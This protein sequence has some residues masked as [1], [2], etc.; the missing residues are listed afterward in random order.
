M[1]QSITFIV[2]LWKAFVNM[3]IVDR[4]T[5]AKVKNWLWNSSDTMAWG[6]WRLQLLR[7]PHSNAQT[8]SVRHRMTIGR[9][10]ASSMAGVRLDSAQSLPLSPRKWR[11]RINIANCNLLIER[12]ESIQYAHSWLWSRSG[13]RC[14]RGYRLIVAYFSCVARVQYDYLTYIITCVRCS[15][16]R[17]W[18]HSEGGRSFYWCGC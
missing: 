7:W 2:S 6:R 5:V 1:T 11:G 13:P 8:T 14:R 16:S 9:W 12:G 17:C 3:L 18:L 10:M 15:W 4:V